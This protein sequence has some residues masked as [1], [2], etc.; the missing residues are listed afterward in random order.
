LITE[1]SPSPVTRLI[2]PLLTPPSPFSDI[3]AAV[4]RIVRRSREVSQGKT[5][6]LRSVAAGFTCAR[7]CLA[8][9][10]P[11]PMPGYPTAPALYPVP[12]RQLRALPPASSPPRLAT[13]Q[14]PSASGSGQPAR[15]GLAPPT[16]T[17]CLAHRKT[18]AGPTGRP[19]CAAI[20][21]RRPGRKAPRSASVGGEIVR[22]FPASMISSRPHGYRECRCAPKQTA[23]TIEYIQ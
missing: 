4:L 8:I 9:G 22:G 3:T 14:L 1:F 19:V 6:I 5:L 21:V 15:K 2:W 23:G 10:H 13:T 16:S 17:P 7:V 12:V 18:P 20:R 11:R